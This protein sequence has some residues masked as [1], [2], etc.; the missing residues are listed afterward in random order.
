[1]DSKRFDELYS[2]AKFYAYI[3][4]MLRKIYNHYKEIFQNNSIDFEDLEQECWA[5]LYENV[6][7][8][9]DNGYCSICM[10]NTAIDMLRSFNAL[11]HEVEYDDEET[12]YDNW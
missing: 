10:K 6:D 5:S 9:K 8:D 2:N 12:E 4:G 7:N 3:R 11:I 1:M